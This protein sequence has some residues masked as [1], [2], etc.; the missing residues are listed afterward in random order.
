MEGNDCYKFSTIRNFLERTGNKPVS[1]TVDVGVNV[2]SITLLIHEFF[3]KARI[4]GFEA[5]EEYFQLAAANTRHVPTI[6]LFN[7]TVT[8][9]HLFFDDLGARPRRERC[10][11]KL[12]KALPGSGPGWGGG[13]MVAPADDPCFEH[14]EIAGYRIEDRTLD[15]ISFDELVHLVLRQSR[16]DEIDLIKM[17]CE[18]SEHSSLGCASSAALER[19]RFIAGEY[20]DIGRFYGVME[21]KLFRTHKVNLTGSAEIGAFFAERL[22]GTRDGILRYDKTGMLVP[23]PW[24]CKRP[25][26]WHVFNETFVLAHER[27]FHGI[28]Q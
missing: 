28:V 5:V 17:D 15:A 4:F 12:L 20:H 26:D 14:K 27:E 23:R 19:V 18:G 7:K 13:S 24:L 16:A 21:G 9:A 25:M 8:G 10:R 11:L 2:G 1:V 3:P 6:H 22:E